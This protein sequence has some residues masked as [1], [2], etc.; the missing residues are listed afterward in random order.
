MKEPA[1]VPL[2]TTMSAR[3]AAPVTEK[4]GAFVHL[5]GLPPAGVV[6]VILNL[7]PVGAGSVTP[8]KMVAQLLALPG[9]LNLSFPTMVP[10]AGKPGVVTHGL[11]VFPS[12]AWTVKISVLAVP[13]FISGGEKVI[14]PFH[15][16]PEGLQVT[17]PGRLTGF[18]EA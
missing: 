2:F 11:A 7:P 9:M 4:A 13:P 12:V 5:V 14:A 3:V 6:Q 1:T 17:L 16:P 15:T 18:E 8:L 10:S